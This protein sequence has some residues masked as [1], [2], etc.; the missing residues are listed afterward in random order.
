MYADDGKIFRPIGNFYG[1]VL[2][3]NDIDS[4]FEWYILILKNSKL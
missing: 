3:Q 1:A 4:F 2:L